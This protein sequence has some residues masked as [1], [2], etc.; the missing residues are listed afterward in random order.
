MSHRSRIE[1]SIERAR[2]GAISPTDQA[3]EFREEWQ[4]AKTEDEREGVLVATND[5]ADGIRGDPLSEEPDHRGNYRYDLKRVQKAG[6]FFGVATASLT[7]LESFVEIWIAESAARSARRE[8][9]GVPSADSTPGA[10]KRS[11][12][13]T[14]GGQGSSSV[15]S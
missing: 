12:T 8:I 11:R 14:G 5:R 10:L 6:E 3:L 4:G 9:T 7:P 1:R 15:I 13:W 2:S